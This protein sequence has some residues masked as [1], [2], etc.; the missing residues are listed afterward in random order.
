MKVLGGGP[1]ARTDRPASEILH[2]EPNVRIVCFHLLPGQSIPAHQSGSTVIVEVVGGGGLFRGEN[3]EVWLAAGEGAI[4]TPLELHAI[5]TR[6]EP[7][8]FLALIAPRP[9]A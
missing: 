9:A 1:A 4:F 3:T 2:D 6:D 5:S 8:R 7:L